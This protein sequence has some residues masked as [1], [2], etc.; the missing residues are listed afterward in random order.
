MTSSLLSPAPATASAL[1]LQALL[2]PRSVAV[3]GASSDPTRIGGRPIAY[4]LAAGF[5]GRLHPVNPSRDSIQGLPCHRSVA[6]IPEPIDL[7]V[8]AVP[9]AGVLAEIEAA[10]AKGARAAVVFSAGFAE[11][12]EAGRESQQALVR[13]CRALGLRL[14]GPNCLGVFNA[15]IG[16]TAT[17]G[18]FL[19]QMPSRNGRIAL[20]SQSGAYASYLFS[21]AAERGIEIG[22]WVT[23]GNEADITIAEV[24][25]HMAGDPAV[26][27]I[28]CAAEGIRDGARLLAALEK[29]RSTGKPVVLIKMGRTAAGAEAAKSHTAALA[30]DDAVFDAVVRQAGALRVANTQDMLDLLYALQ[31]RPPLGGRKLGIVSVSGGAGVLMADAAADSG[32]EVP[33]LP[34]AVQDRLQRDNPFGAMTNPIDVTAQSMND[35]ALVHDPVRALL[36]EGGYDAVVG[37]FMGWLASPVTGPKL[38]AVLAEALEGFGDRTIALAA[39]GAREVFADFARHGMLVYDDPTRAVAALG[40]MAEIGEMLRRPPRAQP[41]LDGVPLLAGD[42]ADEVRAKAILARA[43]LPVLDERAAATAAE[44]GRQAG[45]I[46]GP[47]ALKVV[48]ADLPHKSDVGG[49][50]LGL[51]GAAAVETA[52]AEMLDTIGRLRPDARIDGFLVS[53]MLDDGVEMIVGVHADLV[54]GPVTMVGFGGVL[55]EVL[56]DVAFAH[57]AVTEEEAL[58]MVMGLRGFRLLAGVRGRPP[59]DVDALCRAIAVLSRFGAANAGRYAGIEIN[60]LLVGPAGRGCV[61]LDALVT[62]PKPA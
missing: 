3:I 54:F 7:A 59:C 5:D 11:L 34:A 22:Q 9:A 57:G 25:D 13:R 8:V 18:S 1:G 37:F 50:R 31:T 38:R 16:H 6:A 4:A 47:V 42:E 49:V 44:A 20:V 35:M 30:V 12:G 17:F 24:I 29:A 39:T 52:A 41:L 26:T 56:R 28:G 10:A 2:A 19:Q 36:A 45:A 43:G 53:P 61:M 58:A 27:A 46:G 40:R 14:L 21:M 48:S 60:P 51:S 23:T 15:A 32:L 55:V 62:L 33:P